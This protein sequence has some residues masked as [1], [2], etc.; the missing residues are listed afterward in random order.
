MT[1]YASKDVSF[2]K[3][4]GVWLW[5]DENIKY[6]DALSGIAVCGLGHAHPRVAEVICQQATTLLHT[7]NIYRIQAQEKLGEKLCT[8]SQMERA[9]FCN[10]GAEANEAAIKLARLHGH[11]RAIDN[12]C[13]IVF[14]NSFHG[15]TMATLSATGSRKAHA[16]FEPLVS[17]FIRAPFNDVDTVAQICQSNKSVCAILVEPIQG[18]GGIHVPDENFLSALRALCDEHDLLLMLDEIQTGNGRTGKWFAFQHEDMLP[19]VLTTAKGL[20]NGV[21]IGVCLARDKAAQLFTP[22]MHG[23]TF[24]GNP[25]ACATGIEVLNIIQQEDLLANATAMGE[26]LLNQLTTQLSNDS[27]VS[28]IRGRGLMIGIELNNDCPEIVD[29]AMQK[30]VLINVTAGNVI[31]ILPPLICSKDHI[32]QIAHTVCECI[33]E[34][35]NLSK[36]IP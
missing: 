26:L 35:K 29:I 2:V 19:D 8:F 11:Q 6:L 28:S 21:P 33:A 16:G 18:E 12:P 15:R 9:F 24:G 20:G 23:S 14:E 10:S 13:I 5:D 31:R 36:P 1:T 34:F 30:N 32:T 3:G 4:D 17:G 25:L 7:S 22:G 27:M